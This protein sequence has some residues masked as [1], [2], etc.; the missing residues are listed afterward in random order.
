M[1]PLQKYGLWLIIFSAASVISQYGSTIPFSLG[2]WFGIDVW[3]P[4]SAITVIPLLDVGRSFV[5]H[6]AEQAEVP[7]RKTLFHMLTIPTTVAFFCSWKAGL[8]YPI[9]LGAIVAVNVGGYIDIRVFRW[10][11]FISEKP[12]VRMRFSNAVATASGSLAFFLIAFTN[13]P[14]ALGLPTNDLA[15]SWDM[16]TV[17]IIAQACTIW[18]AGIVM[19]HIIAW[20]IERLESDDRED[21]VAAEVSAQSLSEAD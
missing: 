5:Q 13:W 20:L 18:V 6:Y 12:H 16:I 10:V 17:G 2:T 15:K 9:F 21:T 4:L 7:F 11:R 14:V 3:L 1:T 19:A 8:P